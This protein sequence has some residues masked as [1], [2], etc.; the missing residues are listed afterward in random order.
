VLYRLVFAF[1]VLMLPL[2]WGQ[3]SDWHQQLQQTDRIKSLDFAEFQ[4]RL[5][6]LQLQQAMMTK[7]E[8]HYLQFL[9]AYADLYLGDTESALQRLLPLSKDKSSKEL[10]FRAR[11]LLVNGYLL[12]Q[13]YSQAFAQLELLQQQ[14]PEISQIAAREQGLLVMALAYRYA[15]QP[16]LTIEYAGRLENEPVSAASLCKAKQLKVDAYFQLGQFAEQQT[17]TAEAVKFCLQQQEWLFAGI[18]KSI[19]A[20]Y[21][22]EQGQYQQAL[23]LI[24][25]FYQQ[26]EHTAYPRLL[27]EF[28]LR[29]AEAYFGLDQSQAA[30][31]AA[32]K[33][34][35]TSRLQEHDPIKVAAR[36]IFYRVA[37][38]QKDY[39]QALELHEAY[40]RVLTAMMEENS[41]RTKAYYSAH[42]DV[43]GKQRQIELLDKDNQLLKAQQNLLKH[44][45][46]YQH[47][48]IILLIVV[49]LGL[50]VWLYR[51]FKA[52]A[53]LRLQ[54]ERDLVTGVS[55]KHHFSRQAKLV[56]ARC[57]EKQQD[58]ALVR[59]RLSNLSDYRQ[60]YGEDAA[61]Q[62][63]RSVVQSCRNF[64]RNQDL[65]G[66]IE[67]DEF[68]ILLPG[69]DA[70]KALMV[71][72]ICRDAVLQVADP[73]GSDFALKLQ[74]G[75]S[76]SRR[77]GYFLSQL[78]EEAERVMQQSLSNELAGL[79][80]VLTAS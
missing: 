3:S 50:S 30:K 12:A 60:Q 59:L 72:E 49:S 75:L 68:A 22:N 63:L 67:L 48:L 44:Q 73:L 35:A 17:F 33:V 18:L 32:A 11:A 21:L 16:E 25:Q 10:A 56:L 26:A 24:Q 46:A 23:A 55:N 40:L 79:N 47:L 29:I 58:A 2:A 1:M 61:D 9:F 37:R 8:Q 43:A 45:T 54:A 38:Q 28:D 62:L 77:C 5:S 13:N 80:L 65:F 31:A 76:Q 57:A 7:A 20:S 42:L 53:Q 78:V 66:R 71:A 15:G 69:T 4:Q 34:L 19:Q 39:Q 36:Q 51:V 41:S 27:A 70:D 74:T 6:R 14:L 52:R 64:L